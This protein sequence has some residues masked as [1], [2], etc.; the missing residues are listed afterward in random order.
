MHPRQSRYI[1]VIGELIDSK[2][3]TDRSQFQDHLQTGLAA[4]SKQT[5]IASPYTIILGGEFQAVYRSGQSLFSNLFAIRALLHPESCRFAIAI[6]GL[7]TPINPA[8]AIGMDGPAFHKAREAI[9][10]L[11][12]EKEQLAITGLSRSM[13]AL[14]D[15]LVNLL[16]AST[17][18]WN[19]NRLEVLVGLMKGQTERELANRLD[20]SERA[21]YKNL[22]DGQLREWANLIREVEMRITQVL[23]I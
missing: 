1:A 11:K 20:L 19:A 5:S 9:I 10:T 2:K 12:A 18:N 23:D 15:P 4:I 6:G 3:I 8:Q 22:K 14:V 13:K 21:I 17:G 16:W 7:N